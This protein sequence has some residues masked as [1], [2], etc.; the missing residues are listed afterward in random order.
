[1]DQLIRNMIY[2]YRLSLIGGYTK[3]YADM[4]LDMLI[5]RKIYSDSIEIS[6]RREQWNTTF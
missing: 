1:M 6:T 4:R 3:R 2:V 5:N